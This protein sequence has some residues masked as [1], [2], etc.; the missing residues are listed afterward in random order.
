[1]TV[2]KPLYFAWGL[3]LFIVIVISPDDVTEFQ[4][5]TELKEMSPEST[6]TAAPSSVMGLL[7]ESISDRLKIGD[8]VS[9]VSF[10]DSGNTITGEVVEMGTRITPYPA[11]LQTGPGTRSWG[12]VVEIRLPPENRFIQGE[13]VKIRFFHTPGNSLTARLKSLFSMDKSYAAV[14]GNSFDGS[15]PAPV[16]TQHSG[17][18]SKPDQHRPKPADGLI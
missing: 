11:R 17:A 18:R 1:M 8:P 9:I 3:A 10:T 4:G 16:S 12:R 14:A 6:T 15:A 5:I 13:R 7:H 2:L